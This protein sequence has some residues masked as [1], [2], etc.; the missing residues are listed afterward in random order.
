MLTFYTHPLSPIA[1]RVWITLLE[2]EIPFE[3]VVVNLNGEQRKSQFLALNPF[4]HVPVIVDDGVRVLESL[5]IL[6]YLEAKYPAP[7]LLPQSPEAIAR[8]RMVQM[9]TVHEL[10]P[11]FAA[12]VP[13]NEGTAIDE[14]VLSH[15]YTVFDFFT[16]QLTDMPYFGGEVLS[17]AD[18]TAGAALPLLVRLGIGLQD[19]PAIASWYE[20]LIE[21]PAWQQS[22]PDDD[23]FE[24]WKRWVSLMIKRRKQRAKRG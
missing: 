5:A 13:S 7:S 14:A 4:H 3:S 24:I 17:L 1:R 23:A 15:V 16:E 12:L 22:E 20:R 21:R 11:K 19:Y 10:T 8:M 2:K 6:D 9:V 18:V